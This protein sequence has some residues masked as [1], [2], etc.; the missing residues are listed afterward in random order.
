M[1]RFKCPVC[2]SENY[3]VMQ[4]DTYLDGGKVCYHQECLCYNEECDS[5][6]EIVIEVPYKESDVVIFEV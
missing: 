6:F 1:S 5:S 2:G 4:N 3:E